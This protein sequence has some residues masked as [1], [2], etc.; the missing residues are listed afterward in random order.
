MDSV[1]MYG[2][3]DFVLPQDPVHVRAQGLDLSRLPDWSDIINALPQGVGIK[4]GIARKV[5]KVICGLNHNHPD[6]AAEMNGE[7]DIDIVVSCRG[8]LVPGKRLQLRKEFAGCHFGDM[9]VE[10]KDIEI[11]GDLAAYFRTRDVTMNEC[12]I[13]RQDENPEFVLYYT[14]QAKRDIAD[15]IVA[16]SIHCLHKKFCQM[17]FSHEGKFIVGS[18]PFERCIIRMIKGHGIRYGI[19]SETWDHY[20]TRGLSQKSLYKIF[21]NFVADDRKFARCHRHLTGLGLIGAD[22]DPNLL[23][24]QAV[25]AV[26]ESLA[27]HGKRLTFTEP[28]ADTIEKWI[29][30]KEAEYE[31][32]KFDRFTK[33][34]LG[35]E[36]EPDIEAPV[37]L[38][39]IPRV[40]ENYPTFYA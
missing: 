14:E 36:V 1:L 12:L 5:L 16:P 38:P 37:H 11:S 18:Q 35:I 39:S 23:W 32:W 30:Q 40:V 4:G 19:N 24:G 26:N 10:A 6:F 15:G 17:W 3:R 13:F 31:E 21:K 20:R 7:G 22:S 25:F 34:S 8:I 28:D 33:M 29:C 2:S 27:R 9:Q